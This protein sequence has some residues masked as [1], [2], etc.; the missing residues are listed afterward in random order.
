MQT[1]TTKNGE[2][3][4]FKT[5][6]MDT[7]KL[8]EKHQT[9]IEIVEAIQHFEIMILHTQRS[10]NSLMGWFPDLSKKYDHM[11]IIYQMCIE[12]LKSRYLKT[13]TN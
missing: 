4:I 6:Q 2:T 1:I 7:K 10:R 13:L 12:R 5:K 8:I 3:R 9:C 11:T